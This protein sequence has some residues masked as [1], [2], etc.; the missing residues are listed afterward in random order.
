MCKSSK[1]DG[2]TSGGSRPPEAGQFDDYDGFACTVTIG[3]AEAVIGESID[4]SKFVDVWLGD[5]GA[6]HHIKSSSLGMINVTKC[7]PGTTIR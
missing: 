5:S 6:S 7:P 1:T 3:S 2:S 4:K